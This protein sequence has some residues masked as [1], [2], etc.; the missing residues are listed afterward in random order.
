MV[1][2]VRSHLLLA[3]FLVLDPDP[4]ALVELSPC[5]PEGQ[6]A[7]KK[8]PPAAIVIVIAPVRSSAPATRSRGVGKGKGPKTNQQKRTG[9]RAWALDAHFEIRSPPEPGAPVPAPGEP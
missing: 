8:T 5:V 6:G 4:S 1:E 2:Q 3:H 7:P 9:T